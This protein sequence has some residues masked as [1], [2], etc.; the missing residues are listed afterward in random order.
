MIIIRTDSKRQVVD[1]TDRLEEKLSG[2]GV[3]NVLLQHTTAALTVAD[4]DPGTDRDYLKAIELL[5]PD[6][7]WQHP[8]DPSHFPDHL[9]SSL[10]GVTLTLPYTDGKL[11]L[12]NWQRVILIELDGPRERHLVLTKI[13]RLE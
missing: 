8:H 10:I 6:G 13:P 7:H 11:Q 1:I 2:G 5:T 12:G 9:W 3:V 4:L